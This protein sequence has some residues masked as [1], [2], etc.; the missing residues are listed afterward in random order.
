MVYAGF[1]LISSF[2]DEGQVETISYSQ[3][4]KQVTANNVKEVYAQGYSV[5]GDLKKAA[6]D[7]DSANKTYTKFVTEIPVFANDDQLYQQLT[8]AGV[9]IKAEPISTGSRGFL[10]NL[11]LSLLPIAVLAGL[12]IWVMRRGASMMGGGGSAA[13]ASRR[14][15]SRSRATRSGSPSRT[16]RASTRWRTSSSRSSTT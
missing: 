15:P 5:Q 16:S 2:F 14:R 12:W 13:S 8:A 7:P 10:L 3:F 6:T 4:T 9:E 1:F 11:L